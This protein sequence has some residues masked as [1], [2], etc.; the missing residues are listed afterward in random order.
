MKLKIK[1]KI[2][3]EGLKKYVL[4]ERAVGETRDVLKPLILK[5]LRL[6]IHHFHSKLLYQKPMLRQTEWR[7]QN[8]P[9]TKS[10]G[11]PVTTLFFW[12]IFSSFRTS[13]KK[14]L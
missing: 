9:I 3:K 2:S 8:G 6:E 11:L 4:S 7:V 5:L 14:L 13:K 10:G 12:K 1:Y